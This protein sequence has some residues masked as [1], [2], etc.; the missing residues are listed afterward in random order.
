MSKF[1]KKIKYFVAVTDKNEIVFKTTA[2]T[3]Q[4]AIRI[5]LKEKRHNFALV[6]F[7]NLKNKNK[8]GLS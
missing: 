2:V 5:F 4:E 6:T 7:K 1:E 3:K 8:D